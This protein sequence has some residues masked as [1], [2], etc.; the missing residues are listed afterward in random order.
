MRFS[1]PTSQLSTEL[2][3]LTIR[4]YDALRQAGV[5]VQMICSKT[6]RSRSKYLRIN[7]YQAIIRISDH[8]TPTH[9]ANSDLDLDVVVTNV[10]MIE[11]AELR[12]KQWI[13]ENYGSP[14]IQKIAS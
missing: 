5:S 4:L 6:T 12:A 13:E 14:Q 10:G 3:N 9:H 2:A 1:P 11:A 7:G 8:L